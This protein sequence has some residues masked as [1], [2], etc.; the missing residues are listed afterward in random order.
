MLRDVWRVVLDIYVGSCEMNSIAQAILQLKIALDELNKKAEVLEI[1]LNV[2]AF[3]IIERQICEQ[4]NYPTNYP[5][6]RERLVV[7]GIPIKMESRDESKM[8]M[9]LTE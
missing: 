3:E 4:A 5:V 1:T 6:N 7:Y 2:D 9:A 8:V